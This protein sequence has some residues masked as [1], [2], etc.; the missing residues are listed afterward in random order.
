MTKEREK[1]RVRRI[2]A[3][4]RAPRLWRQLPSPSATS[5]TWPALYTEPP[6]LN[7]A[8][9][10]ARARKESLE[11]SKPPSTEVEKPNSPLAALPPKTDLKPAPAAEVIPWMMSSCPSPTLRCYTN[12]GRFVQEPEYPRFNQ[13][14]LQETVWGHSVIQKMRIL[15]Y[16]QMYRSANRPSRLQ[17]TQQ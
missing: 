2:S 17:P 8:R 14:L 6:L 16:H 1:Q 13:D 9:K 5:F 15:L 10:E 3:Q 11:I 4:E 7:K 12:I